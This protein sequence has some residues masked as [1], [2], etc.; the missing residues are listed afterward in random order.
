VLAPTLFITGS[1]HPD[2]SPDQ[3]RA[4]AA[5]VPQGSIHVVDGA[6][7]LVPLEAPAEFSRCVREFWTAH[8]ASA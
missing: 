6:A 1:A 2:W 5:L 4:A 3:M 8:P 7:Y